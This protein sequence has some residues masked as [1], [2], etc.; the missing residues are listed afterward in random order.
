MGLFLA[1]FSLRLV[2]LPYSTIVGCLGVNLHCEIKVSPL[3]GLEVLF[4]TFQLEFLVPIRRG[5]EVVLVQD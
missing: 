1:C 3:V 2:F 4:Y 5:M